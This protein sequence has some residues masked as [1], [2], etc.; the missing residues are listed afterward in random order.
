MSHRGKYPSLISGKTPRFVISLA[1]RRCKHC[2]KELSKETN[3][4]EVGPSVGH[5][6]YCYECFSGMLQQSLNDLKK[7]E[8]DFRC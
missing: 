8:A 1:K 2:K 3:C 7:I 4:V 5:K 6:T